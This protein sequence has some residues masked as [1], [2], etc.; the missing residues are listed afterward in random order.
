M[1]ESENINENYRIDERETLI[2]N[3][4]SQNTR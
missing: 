4:E 2:S 3:A 1:N